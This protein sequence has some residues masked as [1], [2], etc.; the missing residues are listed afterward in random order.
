MSDST[1][2][3]KSYDEQRYER[4]VESLDEY[5]C[6]DEAPDLIDEIRKGLAEVKEHPLMQ[7]K[8]ITKLQEFFNSKPSTNFIVED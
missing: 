8:K 4:L 5:V 2:A 1:W 7:V 3:H 6:D